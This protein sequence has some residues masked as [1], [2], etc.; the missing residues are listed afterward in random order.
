[1]PCCSVL[2]WPVGNSAEIVL[3]MV[4]ARPSEAGGI[5]MSLRSTLPRP[6]P[7]YPAPPRATVSALPTSAHRPGPFCARFERVGRGDSA[8]RPARLGRDYLEGMARPRHILA[9][10]IYR[11]SLLNTL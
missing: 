9:L 8:G 2:L 4:A 10:A 7:P 11:E 6:A 3:A 1:M 5:A